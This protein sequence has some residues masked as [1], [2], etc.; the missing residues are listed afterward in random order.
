MVI[1]GGLVTLISLV[2]GYL[3]EGGM[4]R[5]STRTSTGRTLNPLWELIFRFGCYTVTAIDSIRV[6]E[7]SYREMDKWK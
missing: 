7:K 4:H 5:L 6:L 2:R 1:V 3:Y